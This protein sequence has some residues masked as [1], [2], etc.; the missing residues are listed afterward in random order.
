MGDVSMP[1]MKSHGAIES[2][3]DKARD[4]I[5]FEAASL[6]ARCLARGRQV[7]HHG[8]RGGVKTPIAAMNGAQ[9]NEVVV[10]LNGICDVRVI[11]AS[12][13]I[14]ANV[15]RACSKRET[16]NSQTEQ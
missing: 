15:A 14:D 1:V 9:N 7:L 12:A 6:V 13:F 2:A 16:Q 5:R 4:K 10:E 8:I 3:S 11:K